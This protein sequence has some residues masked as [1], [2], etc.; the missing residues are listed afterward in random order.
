MSDL[1]EK[2]TACMERAVEAK[3]A[4]GYGLL[5]MKNGQELCHAVAG[6]AELATGKKVERDS[7]FRLYSQSKP[8]TAAAVMIL[9]ERGVI[10]LM[11]GVDKYLPGFSNGQIIDGNGKLTP[12]VRAP[13]IMELLGMTAGLCYPDVD[14]AG[15]EAARVF[16]LQQ[17]LIAEGRG[18][19]TVTFCNELGKIPRAFQPGTCWRYSTCADILGAVVE[20]AS[21]KKF[22][23]FLKEEIFDPLGMKDTAF[24]VPAE[25]QDRL[26]TV[27][28]RGEDGLKEYHRQH[29]AVGLYDR[30]PAWESGGAGL[31][32]TLDD[33]AAFAGMLMGGGEYHGARILKPA[34]VRYMTSPQLTA[35]QRAYMWDSLGGYSYGKLMRHCVEP[36]ACAHIASAGEYGWDGWLGTYFAN[37][38]EENITFLMF[39]NTTDTGTSS[40][41]RK[42]RSILAAEML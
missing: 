11:D 12:A 14:A 7:I 20:V 30:E 32:S 33:Y 38:P 10:D 35:A 22:G 8:I 9:A 28:T 6:Y 5:I 29:L 26:V 16:D 42:C 39:Q 15:R 23:D 36:G 25:K 27:Y 21:G 3:E 40:V 1:R 4:A 17:A 37:L 41:V 34:T 24:W 31:V 18:M 2:L 13:W 19:D